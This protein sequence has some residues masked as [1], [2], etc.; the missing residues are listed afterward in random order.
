MQKSGITIPGGNETSGDATPFCY[1]FGIFFHERMN[2]LY[3]SD[4]TNN[5]VLKFVNRSQTEILVAGQREN[6][7]SNEYIQNPN[8]IYGDECEMLFAKGVPIARN[9]GSL[10]PLASKFDRQRVLAIDQYNNIYVTD[11]FYHRIQKWGPNDSDGTT[12]AGGTRNG[13]GVNQLFFSG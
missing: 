8:N 3:V 11:T 13:K 5:R 12:I 10:S 1:I 4:S 9:A 7:P 6:G 2:T